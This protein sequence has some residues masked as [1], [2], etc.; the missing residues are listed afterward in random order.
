MTIM[1]GLRKHFIKNE[2]GFTLSEMMVTIMIM[3]IVFFALYSIFDMSIRVFSFGNN[4]VEAVESA[5]IGMDKMEREIRQAYPY[6]SASNHLFFT[7]ANPATA[8]ALPAPDADGNVVVNELTFGNELGSGDGAITCGSPCEYIT[9]KL[10]NADGTAACAGAP[11]T[12]WRVGPP[13]AA[14]VAEN[15]ALNGLSFTLLKSDGTTPTDEG[16]VG[17]VLVKLRVVVD[18]GL[19]QDGTQTLTTLIDLRNR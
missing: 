19:G 9:Y 8:M 15:V 4:K 11:C 3:M 7:T 16:Q 10:T 18:Q 6:S 2:Q 5:R 1:S 14:P 12:L 13:S 17:L